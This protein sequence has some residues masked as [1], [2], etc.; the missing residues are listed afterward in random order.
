MAEQVVVV[1]SLS[2]VAKSHLRVSGV[3]LSSVE[4][5]AITDADPWEKMELNLNKSY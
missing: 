2:S 5:P 3:A 1:G 4:L